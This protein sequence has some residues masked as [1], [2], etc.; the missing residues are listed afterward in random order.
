MT[1]NETPAEFTARMNATGK[2]WFGTTVW[3]GKPAFRLS[4][5]SW[6][7]TGA[8]IERVIEILTDNA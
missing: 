8:D 5:S 4:V 1:G 6:R 2:L 3:Q 7:T